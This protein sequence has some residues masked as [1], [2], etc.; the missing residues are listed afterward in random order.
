MECHLGPTVNYE[1]NGHPSLKLSNKYGWSEVFKR[2]GWHYE[3]RS[4]FERKF[5]S[6]VREN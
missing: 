3:S 2:Y 5:K 1:G 6:M 4:F